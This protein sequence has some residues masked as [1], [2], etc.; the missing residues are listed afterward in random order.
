MFFPVK[1]SIPDPVIVAVPPKEND[2]FTLNGETTTSEV[3]NG[4]KMLIHS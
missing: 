4:L 2:L 3:V 1:I